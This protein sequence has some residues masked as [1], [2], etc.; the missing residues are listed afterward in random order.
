MSASGWS[1]RTKDHRSIVTGPVSMPFTGFVVRDWAYRAHSRVIGARSS[2]VSEEHRGPHATRTVGL[3]PS[4]LGQ[5]KPAHLGGEVAHHV[6]AFGLAVDQHIETDAFLEGDDA[7]DLGFERA[8]VLICRRF[9]RLATR[10][11]PSAARWSGGTTR[12]W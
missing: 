6:V 4:L 9:A 2:H 12:W 11:E 5:Y 1:S 10:P 7:V 3:D 8:P